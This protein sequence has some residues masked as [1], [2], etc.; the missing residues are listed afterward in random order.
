MRAGVGLVEVVGRWIAGGRG[1]DS[2]WPKRATGHVFIVACV[3]TG[4][5]LR[6]V[7]TRVGEVGAGSGLGG[8]WREKR[9]GTVVLGVVVK[10]Q[11]ASGRNR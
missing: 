3:G 10:T 2:D 9:A 6:A 1:W 4:A 8:S 11:G 5:R 7:S